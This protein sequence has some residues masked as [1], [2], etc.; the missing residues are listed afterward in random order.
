[1]RSASTRIRPTCCAA[2]TRSEV[3]AKDKYD[4]RQLDGHL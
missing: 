3:G 1:V 4:G 2:S